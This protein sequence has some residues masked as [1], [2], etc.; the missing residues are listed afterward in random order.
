MWPDCLHEFFLEFLI[1][2]VQTFFLSFMT[3][4]LIP[5]N[6][7]ISYC[8]IMHDA[9]TGFLFLFCLHK[10]DYHTEHYISD[11]N[12]ISSWDIQ[13]LKYRLPY[14]SLICSTWLIF[15]FRLSIIES[16]IHWLVDTFSGFAGLHIFLH[17]V[18]VIWESCCNVRTD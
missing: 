9:L 10:A 6:F 18:T 13:F 8:H 14:I 16:V 2:K 15:R 1:L 7:V 3:N 12:T 11:I 5:C 4:I 17:F